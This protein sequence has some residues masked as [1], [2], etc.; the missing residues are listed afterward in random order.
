MESY[1]QRLNHVCEIQ[2]KYGMEPRTDS[3][4]TKKYASGETDMTAQ[5]VAK[6]LV[7]V[8]YIYKNTLYGEFIEDYMREIAGK[9]K[10]KYRITWTQAWDITRFYGP[11]SLK[12]MCMK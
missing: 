2:K 1:E 7:C 9:L 8:D 6:E 10:N 12:L 3:I 5:E 11:T 4:L